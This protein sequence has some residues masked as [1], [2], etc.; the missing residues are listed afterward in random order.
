MILRN[1]EVFGFYEAVGLQ[2]F[3]QAID[4]CWKFHEFPWDKLF[5]LNSVQ[6]TNPLLLAST[7]IVTELKHKQTRIQLFLYP[8]DV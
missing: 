1:S 8:P 6:A 4:G 7:Q 2:F 5:F 3:P